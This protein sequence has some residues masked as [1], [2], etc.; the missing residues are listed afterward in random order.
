MRK[1]R[2]DECENI[3]TQLSAYYDNQMPTWKRY[4][5]RRHLKQCSACSA[6][7]VTIKQT[8]KLLRL[9]EPVEASDNF[10]SAVMSRAT[11]LHT[12]QKTHRSPLHRIGISIENLQAWIRSNVRTYDIVY[13]FGLIFA[14]FLMVG[15]TLYSPRI[16]RLNPF[17]HFSSKSAEIQQERV[18]S[19]EVILQE[20][21]KPKIR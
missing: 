19:F 2:T 11:T 16:E 15:V 7:V 1:Y 17:T 13:M 9:A 10:L 5:V 20:K 3:R 8:D 6:Q 4:P 12:S 18:I 14:V 21:P